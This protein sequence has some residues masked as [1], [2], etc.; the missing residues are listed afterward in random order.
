MRSLKR[1]KRLIYLCHQYEDRGIS[2]YKEPISIKVN[3]QV[4][5]NE[6]DLIALGT[7]YPTYLRIKTDL[8]NKDLFHTGDRAYVNCEPNIPFDVL[9]KDANYEIDSEPIVSLNV[10][11]VT[12][13]KLSDKQ[14]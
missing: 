14:W 13:K 7:E 3:Y 2:K 6:S 5:N 9:C 8:K 11:E 1:N 10:V 12:L 4:T